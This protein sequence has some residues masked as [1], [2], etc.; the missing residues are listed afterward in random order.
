M[1]FRSGD[2]AFIESRNGEFITD[3]ESLLGRVNDTLSARK[4]NGDER[5]QVF[6]KE[7]Y[8]SELIKLKNALDSMDAGVINRTVDIL[9]KISHTEDAAA[10]IRNISNNILIAE[11]DEAAVLIESLLQ[12]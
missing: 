2:S 6:D 12:V 7:T 11:Y 5:N 9:K 4:R 3:L 8:K 10:A 1:L